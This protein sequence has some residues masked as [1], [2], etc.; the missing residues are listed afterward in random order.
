MRPMHQL[1]N[2]KANTLQVAQQSGLFEV[3]RGPSIC[4]ALSQ[5]RQTD[6][7]WKSWAR[8]ESAKR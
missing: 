7:A 4:E 8:I 1:I 3:S 6:A 5:E 2:I